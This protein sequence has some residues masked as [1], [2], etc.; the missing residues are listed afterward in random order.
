MTYQVNDCQYCGKSHG[1]RCPE[2]RAIEYYE[3]GAVKRVEFMTVSDYMAPL[4][5]M[6]T[7]TFSEPKP[8]THPTWG[9]A[10]GCQFG[11]DLHRD[12]V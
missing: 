3:N 9:P 12:G 1:R 5:P 11:S 10:T 4:R 2:V 7:L 6:P 8:W